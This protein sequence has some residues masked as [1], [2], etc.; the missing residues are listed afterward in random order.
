MGRNMISK[1]PKVANKAVHSAKE[2]DGG[3]GGTAAV[4]ARPAFMAQWWCFVKCSQQ[5]TA[6]HSVFQAISDWNSRVQGRDSQEKKL[7]EKIIEKLIE[8]EF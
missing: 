5:W 4:M 2:G 6:E 3:M 8:T 7:I 1:G